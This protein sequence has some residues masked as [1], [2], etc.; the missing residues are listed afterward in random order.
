MLDI[1]AIKRILPHRYPFLLVDRIIEM[2]P[3]KRAMGIKN[4]T[5]N[6]DFFNG[7]FP[8]HPVMP[9]VLVLEAMAQVGGV[10]LLSMT[11]N[12]GKLAYFGGMDKIRFRRTVLP[13]DQMVTEVTLLKNRGNIGKVW[14][15]TKV[16]GQVAAE[17]EF[18]FALVASGDTDG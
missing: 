11:G 7:H 13:G 16:D 1:N 8:G 15:E 3:G 12:E 18:T 4:V 17:G 2:E 5:I 10:L 9:G 14:V 6:E